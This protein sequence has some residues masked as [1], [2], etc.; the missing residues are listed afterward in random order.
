MSPVEIQRNREADAYRGVLDRLDA[1]GMA[2][3]RRQLAWARRN[4]LWEAAESYKGIIREYSYSM[5]VRAGVPEDV[6]HDR[7]RGAA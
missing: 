4:G 7:S 1:E 3:A 5:L 2:L 6:A